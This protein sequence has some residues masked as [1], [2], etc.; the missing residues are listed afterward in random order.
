LETGSQLINETYRQ[1]AELQSKEGART[2][3][4]DEKAGILAL[5]RQEADLP[6]KPGKVHRREFEYTRHGTQCFI[7]SFD[8]VTGQIENP[9][10]GDIGKYQFW[11]RYGTLVIGI[12][13]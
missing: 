10:I 4:S 6:M 13:L 12:W 9:I 1:A 2:I 8:V 5:E 3:S 7:A 11:F